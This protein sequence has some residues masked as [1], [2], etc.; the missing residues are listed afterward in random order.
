VRQ[1]AS[2]TQ[3]ESSRQP[4]SSSKERH[5]SP[6]AAARAARKDARRAELE[7]KRLERSI[8]K[9]AE[10]ENRLTEDMQASATNHAQLAELQVELERIA[11][12]RGQ[13]ETAWFELSESLEAR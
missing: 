12:E 11:G 6:G 7:L 8:E 5:V 4:A 9:L 3:P 13:L 1:G 2:F 10:H